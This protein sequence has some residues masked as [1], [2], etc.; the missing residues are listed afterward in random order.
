MGKRS[1]KLAGQL[2]ASGLANGVSQRSSILDLD[3]YIPLGVG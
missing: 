2:P 1:W 3:L